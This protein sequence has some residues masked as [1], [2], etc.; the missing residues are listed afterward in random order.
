MLIQMVIFNPLVLGQTFDIQ[1]NSISGTLVNLNG[2]TACTSF[3]QEKRICL[4][5][6][7]GPVTGQP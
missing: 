4:F 2:L 5:V 6:E 3:A 7:D 1:Y